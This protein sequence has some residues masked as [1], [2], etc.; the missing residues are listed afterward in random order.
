MEETQVQETPKEITPLSRQQRRA[1]LRHIEKSI[2]KAVKTKEYKL[3]T[4][5]IG[6]LDPKEFEILQAGT[7]SDPKTQVRF[8]HFFQN[9]KWLVS[10]EARRNYLLGLRKDVEN[11]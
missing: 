6:G 10:M 2:K 3:T 9:M 8:N 4:D 5:Y 1:E 11:T 7:H